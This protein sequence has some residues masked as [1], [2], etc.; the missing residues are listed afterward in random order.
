M[1]AKQTDIS[2]TDQ[3]KRQKEGERITSLHIPCGVP[4]M[5]SQKD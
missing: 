3:Y 4:Q 2:T 1:S 5:Q